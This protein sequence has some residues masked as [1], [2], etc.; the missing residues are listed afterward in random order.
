MYEDEGASHEHEL[1]EPRNY[2][3]NKFIEQR[4]INETK[5][6]IRDKDDLVEC[7]RFLFNFI[8]HGKWSTLTLTGYATFTPSTL[9]D[10]IFKSSRCICGEFG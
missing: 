10:I 4:Y 6:V 8:R 9:F 5:T 3:E 2:S 1:Y 7:V